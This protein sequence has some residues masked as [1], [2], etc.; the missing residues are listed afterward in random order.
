MK[1][2]TAEIADQV[3][4]DTDLAEAMEI[5]RTAPLIVA[6]STG[7]G[8]EAIVLNAYAKLLPSFPRLQLAIIPRKPERFDEVAKMI[9]THGYPCK[10]RSKRPD[11]LAMSQKAEIGA[12]PVILGDTTGELRKFYALA[13]VVFVGRSLVSFGGSD[14]I[15]VA[16]LARPMC[17]GPYMENFA[18][19]VEKLCANEAAISMQGENELITAL[20]KLLQGKAAAEAMGKRAQEVVRRNTGATRKTISLLRESVGCDL[21]TADTA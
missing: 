4:G 20:R 19:A 7:P 1:Y 12:A 17:F 21:K 6:G 5:D 11:H 18:E 2:D 8:E 10:R 15:E 3:T 9:E 13:D 16:A 14:P